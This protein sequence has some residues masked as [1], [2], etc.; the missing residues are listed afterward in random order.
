[1]YE[2]EGGVT[3]VKY[4][5]TRVTTGQNDISFTNEK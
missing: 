4:C 1:M 5:N 2:A 3:N